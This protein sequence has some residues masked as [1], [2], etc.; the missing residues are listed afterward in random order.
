VSLA[1]FADA[2]A[3]WYRHQALTFNSFA[4]GYGGGIHFLLP[5]SIVARVEYAWNEYR[6]G[7]FILDLR[8]SL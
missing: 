8:G 7:Q 4:S 6:R 2:G 1:I 5:Y 3:T